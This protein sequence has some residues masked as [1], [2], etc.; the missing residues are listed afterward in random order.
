MKI[1]RII[2]SIPELPPLPARYEPAADANSLQ[3]N[4]PAVAVP[5]PFR[6]PPRRSSRPHGGGARFPVRSV[7]ALAVISAI[8]W[9]AVGWS[10]R[11]REQASPQRPPERLARE[12]SAAGG[13]SGAITP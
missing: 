3:A 12:T 7:V 10:E 4:A 6:C 11:H 5:T 2:A 9:A 8:C 1:I 13:Q